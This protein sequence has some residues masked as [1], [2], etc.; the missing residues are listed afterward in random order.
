[1]ESQVNDEL[2]IEQN[3]A[4]GFA[5]S[6]EE[7]EIQPGTPLSIGGPDQEEDGGCFVLFS[8]YPTA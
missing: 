6:P 2:A 4:N 8:R 5:A 3:L 1:M 7:N